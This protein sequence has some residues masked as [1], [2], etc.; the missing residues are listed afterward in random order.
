MNSRILKICKKDIKFK[1]MM[2]I[3]LHSMDLSMQNEDL[4]LRALMASL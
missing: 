3:T 1:K 2:K 4:V